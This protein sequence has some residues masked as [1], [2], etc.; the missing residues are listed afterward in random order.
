MSQGQANTLAPGLCPGVLAATALLRSPT[1]SCLSTLF[2]VRICPLGGPPASAAA[3]GTLRVDLVGAFHSWLA[4]SQSP[5][6]HPCHLVTTVPRFLGSFSR[7]HYSVLS[8]QL[9]RDGKGGAV[10]VQRCGSQL[11]L[12]CNIQSLPAGGTDAALHTQ[13][14]PDKL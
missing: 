6:V 3:S 14:S 10:A 7:V 2:V 5:V 11:S 9:L 8:A 4:A 1:R 13:N 12:A